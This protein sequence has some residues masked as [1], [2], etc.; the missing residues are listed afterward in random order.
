[1][2]SL[3]QVIMISMLEPRV[4]VIVVG[5]A[6]ARQGPESLG[7][8]IRGRALERLEVQQLDDPPADVIAA[9]TATLAQ[10]EGEWWDQQWVFFLC[11]LG[12]A[13]RVFIRVQSV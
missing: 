4:I 7:L 5:L 2:L 6:A 9:F 12:E 11:L 1:M 10:L 13:V 3:E 8:G